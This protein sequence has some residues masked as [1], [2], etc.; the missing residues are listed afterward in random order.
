MIDVAPRRML[1]T[2]GIIEFVAKETVLPI[3]QEMQE[4]AERGQ[5]PYPAAER[6]MPRLFMN[7]GWLSDYCTFFA[8]AA[9]EPAS[10]KLAET[11][12]SSFG[13]PFFKYG[14]PCFSIWF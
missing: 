11:M 6:A 4:R 2:G 5:N 8:G 14:V 13:H 1:A 3:K 10:T 9:A 12:K 7:F